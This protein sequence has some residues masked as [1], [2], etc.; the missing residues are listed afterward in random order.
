MRFA[1]IL[2]TEADAF[3]FRAD[4]PLYFF[5]FFFKQTPSA[6]TLLQNTREL[7]VLYFPNISKKKV[8]RRR[9]LWC[10]VYEMRSIRPIA[11]PPTCPAIAANCL[12][13]CPSICLSIHQ[14]FGTPSVI[15]ANRLRTPQFIPTPFQKIVGPP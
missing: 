15:P 8:I 10:H 4:A 7:S 1:F 12:F 3:L 5:L 2:K 9:D 14:I 11:C 6:L 13:L